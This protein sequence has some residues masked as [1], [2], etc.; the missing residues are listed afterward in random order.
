MTSP[1]ASKTGSVATRFDATRQ[2][3]RV[4]FHG[5]V[6]RDVM[7]QHLREIEELEPRLVAG[8]TLASD[9]S[10]LEEIEPGCLE[11]L[12][13]VMETL[14]RAGVRTVVR[15][16]PNPEKDIGFAILSAFHYPTDVSCFTCETA[17]DYR[18]WLDSLEQDG[19]P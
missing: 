13:R 19:A 3:L 7:S 12:I 9:L 10:E 1:P 18:H 6:T 17:E 2:I 8:F 14:R 15:W 5:R 4:R 11:T 16:I